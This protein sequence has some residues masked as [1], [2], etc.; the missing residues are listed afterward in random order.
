MVD[1]V[2][3]LL[4]DLLL[5]LDL[6][7]VVA[8]LLLGLRQADHYLVVHVLLPLQL[9]LQLFL[10]KV[11]DL[12]FTHEFIHSV[13]VQELPITDLA[14]VSPLPLF[15]LNL[16]FR[17][18][19]GLAFSLGVVCGLLERPLLEQTFGAEK[20]AAEVTKKRQMISVEKSDLPMLKL[21]VL[22]LLV[23]TAVA[24]GPLL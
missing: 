13:S 7:G 18:L 6:L 8:S 1:L 10:C 5:S 3:P 20:L 16:R 17:L 19:S 23:T 15:R 11:P 9:F 2:Y 21:L 14:D 22:H 4:L 12:Q 24:S